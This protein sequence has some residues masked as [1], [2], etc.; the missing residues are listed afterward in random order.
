MSG[1]AVHRGKDTTHMT[2]ET[3]CNARAWPQQC[4][5]SRANGSKIVALRFVDHG[6]KEE[7][8]MSCQ[9][10]SLTSFKLCKTTPN[11]TQQHATGW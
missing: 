10:K 2:L 7:L 8:G 4:W 11:N 9:F 1:P 3:M 6:T 5:A